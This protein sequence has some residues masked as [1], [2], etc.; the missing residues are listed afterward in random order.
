MIE[1]LIQLLRHNKADDFCM[2][3]DNCDG[4]CLECPFESDGSL[5]E[6]IKELEAQNV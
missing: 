6:F 3:L 1:K 5:N 2:K 4:K